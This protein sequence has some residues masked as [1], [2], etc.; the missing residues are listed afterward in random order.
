MCGIIGYLGKSP[1]LPVLLNGLHTLEYRG[2]DSAG[3]AL[4]VN[5]HLSL[6]KQSG[7]VADLE[8]HIGDLQDP[9]Y[10]DA[11]CG[12]AH[13]RWATHGAPTEANAHPHLSAEGNI[14]VVHNGIVDNYL[15]IKDSLQQRGSHT[16]HSDTDTEVLAHLIGACYQTSLLEAVEMACQQIKGTFGLCVISSQ[17]PEA[18]VV[19]RRGSPIAIG[20]G[21]EEI[22][23]AS[24]P[25]S[26][27][28]YTKQVVYLEDNDIAYLDRSGKISIHAM[29]GPT[30]GR[31]IEDI[32]W[33]VGGADRGDFE[34]FMIKEIHDQSE[35]MR[36]T[37]RG[38]LNHDDGTTYLSGLKMGPADLQRINE[39]KIVAC[40]TSL[41]AGLLG[42][43]IL[44]DVAGIPVEVKQAADFSDYPLANEHTL[45]LAISQS[46]ET[47]DTLSAIREAKQ[48]NLEVAAIVNSEGSTLA[49]ESG[50]GI[51]IHA[52][53]EISVASTKAFGCQAITLQMLALK[54][55]RSRHIN[56]EQGKEM[57]ENIERT[58]ELIESVVDNQAQIIAMAEQLAQYDKCFIIGRGFFYPVAMEGALKIK[59]VSYIHAEGYHSAELKHGP[60]A[61]L[62]PD[63]PVIVL[64]HQRAQY[65]KM[66][67]AIHE[68]HSR[69]SPMFGLIGTDDNEAAAQL[70]H[71]IELPT[72]PAGTAAIVYTTALQLLAYHTARLRGCAIDQP[73]HLAKSV[74]VE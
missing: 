64:L 72:A 22:I 25:I 39:L 69:G 44:E 16:F 7:K 53:P 13:T 8:T 73:R 27:V 37:I 60:L 34:H 41:F 30:V 10:K 58:P 67:I 20:I 61:L 24:D 50:R 26:I 9:I 2:Y 56:R 3:L 70:E 14:A 36:N 49:R 1:A 11:K 33:L 48:R 68:C 43:Y 55:G 62:G 51:Y 21:E 23:V 12:I 57:L 4:N 29:G 18:L 46:G 54:F 38:R 59:E 6:W 52:G 31:K 15:E 19:A 63:M 47:A 45:I 40:G 32:G 71:C 42:K 35:S 66:M 65:K 17:E 28:A 74:T 5:K